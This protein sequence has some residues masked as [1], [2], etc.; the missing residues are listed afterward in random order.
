[1]SQEP[2]AGEPPLGASTS[3]A[4]RLLEA[5]FLFPAANSAAPS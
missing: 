1:M 4:S 2:W 3:P 5:S